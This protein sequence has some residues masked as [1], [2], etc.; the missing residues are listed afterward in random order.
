MVA[1]SHLPRTTYVG[2]LLI[3]GCLSLLL[4]DCGLRVIEATPL[5]RILPVVEPIL[6]QPDREFGFDSTPGARGVWPREHRARGSLNSLWAPPPSCEPILGQPDREFGF[7][8][9]PGAHGVWSCEHRARVQLNSLGL[10]A[11]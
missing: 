2:R 4:V 10:H 5:W 1:L 3:G 6:G 11:R 8:S 7:D 9:T